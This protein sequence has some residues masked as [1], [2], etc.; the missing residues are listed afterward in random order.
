MSSWWSDPEARLRLPDG[1]LVPAVPAAWLLLAH[2]RGLAV[3]VRDDGR[4]QVA[5][6]ARLTED[7]RRVLAAFPAPLRAIPAPP[8]PRMTWR[9][10]DGEAA[11]VGS[12]DEILA[13]LE[14][15]RATPRRGRR[16]A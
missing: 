13:V 5:P 8:P 9:D 15:A 12:V 6:A 2:W 16:R 10:D 11:V 3:T 14:Q 1:R 7:D 4:L